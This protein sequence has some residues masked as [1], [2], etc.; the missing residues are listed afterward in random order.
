M[1][2]ESIS[3]PEERIPDIVRVI[4]RGLMGEENQE[5]VEQLTQQCD[6][7]EEYWEKD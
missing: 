3:F 4:R 6:D 5:V 2:R 1:G 7:L